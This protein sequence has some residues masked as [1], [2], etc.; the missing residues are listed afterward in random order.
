MAYGIEIST[1]TGYVFFSTASQTWNYLG[2]LT[3]TANSTGTLTIPAISLMKRVIFQRFAVNNPPDNQEGYIH[4]A[5]QTTSDPNTI[6]VSG[7]NVDTLVIV[8]GQ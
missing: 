1:N 2:Q 5:A 4:T 8:L 3:V 7:G 6:S